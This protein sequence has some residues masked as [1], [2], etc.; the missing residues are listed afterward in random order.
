M[1]QGDVVRKLQLPAVLMPSRA[2]QS[3]YGVVA[4]Q[5]SGADLGE[6]PVHHVDVHGG[7]DE[8]DADIA[9]WAEGAEDVGPLVAEVP[10]PAWPAALGGP[11]VCQGSLLANTGFVLP[12][13]F[14]RFV[15]G[16]LRDRA[17]DQVGKVFCLFLDCGVVAV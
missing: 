7:Q 9:G 4:G 8:C 3:E 14:D 1:E 15:A 12:P 17:G 2:V 6:V 13:Q 11:D 16:V 5:D 10:G